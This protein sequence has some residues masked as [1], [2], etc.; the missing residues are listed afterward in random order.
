VAAS[1]PTGEASELRGSWEHGTLFGLH[2]PAQRWEQ[3]M[4]IAYSHTAAS[5]SPAAAVL[6]A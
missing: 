2:D 1:G 3:R 4:R 6:E 5:A